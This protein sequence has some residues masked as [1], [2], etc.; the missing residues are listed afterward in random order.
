VPRSGQGIKRVLNRSGLRSRLFLGQIFFE[1]FLF[2]Q[3]K[4][5]SLGEKFAFF[6]DLQWFAYPG[7]SKDITIPYIES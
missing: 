5:A 3:K 4:Y 6:Y 2:D 7:G 1:T